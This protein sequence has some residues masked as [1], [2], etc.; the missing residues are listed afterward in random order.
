MPTRALD[1]P[2]LAS[3]LL[4]ERLGGLPTAIAACAIAPLALRGKTKL[5]EVF[6]FESHEPR[7]LPESVQGGA[8]AGPR[9]G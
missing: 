2:A 3:S 9:R 4:L 1:R 5:L 6:A 8:L 7:A